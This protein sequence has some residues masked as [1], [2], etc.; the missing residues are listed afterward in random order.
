M[1]NARSRHYVQTF[2]LTSRFTHYACLEYACRF[3]DK[4]E[5]KAHFSNPIKRAQK[6]SASEDAVQRG[7]QRQKELKKLLSA[8][9]LCRTKSV[10]EHELK[11]KDDIIVFCELSELQKT[12]YKHLLCLPDFHN[13][14][15]HRRRKHCG[16]SPQPCQHKLPML[17][18]G[19]GLDERYAL[20]SLCGGIMTCA[21]ALDV[22][23]VSSRVVRMDSIFFG[24]LGRCCGYELMM[25]ISK[26][27]VAARPV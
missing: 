8:Y 13:A 6:K 22:L 12:I 24:V 4:K 19:S 10:I 3:L 1:G 15:Y 14:R 2:A 11:G 18:D 27:A 5:W 9:M 7:R 21:V 20:V 17:P 16:C 23:S 25:I 26:D